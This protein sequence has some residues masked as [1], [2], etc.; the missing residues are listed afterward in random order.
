M[1]PDVAQPMEGLWKLNR[2]RVGC[3]VE[4]LGF[5]C[6]IYWKWLQSLDQ[7]HLADCNVFKDCWWGASNI[8]GA[9]ICKMAIGAS[10]HYINFETIT[11]NSQM[12]LFSSLFSGRQSY[13]ALF[14]HLVKKNVLIL[15]IQ[16]CTEETRKL[17]I[18][19]GTSW[20]CFQFPEVFVST[21]FKY[22][23]YNTETVKCIW[24][25]KITTVQ[26]VKILSRPQRGESKHASGINKSSE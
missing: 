18:L 22:E 21:S 26:N 23:D 20:G 4:D 8:W 6:E 9:W 7:Y 5:N 25:G 19:T 15:T 14:N 16:G 10:R 17:L 24:R 2:M 11:L 13:L 1:A 12:L 3:I